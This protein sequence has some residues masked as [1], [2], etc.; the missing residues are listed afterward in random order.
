MMAD[1]ESLLSQFVIPYQVLPPD[2]MPPGILKSTKNV[3]CA[4]IKN[5]VGLVGM[6]RGIVRI[7]RGS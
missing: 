3:Q 4:N 5:G 1:L 7:K 2:R 6:I